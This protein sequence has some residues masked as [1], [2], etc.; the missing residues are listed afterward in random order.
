ML[1]NINRF[2]TW[3]QEVAGSNPAAPTIQQSTYGNNRKC[4]FCLCHQGILQE[5]IKIVT[6]LPGL[7]HRNLN[8]GKTCTS[9]R[10]L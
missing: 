8:Y 3:E 1:K 6:A 7:K 5:P 10:V 4:F 9:S 2:L